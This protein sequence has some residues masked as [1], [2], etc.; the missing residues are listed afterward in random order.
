[1]SRFS[2]REQMATTASAADCLEAVRDTLADLGAGPRMEGAVIVGNLGS[3]A[4]TRLFGSF[5]GSPSWLPVKISAE[6]ID[7]ETERLVIVDVA[8][9]FGFGTL[10]GAEGGF[11]ARCQQVLLQ[12]T[13]GVRSRLPAV[14]ASSPGG[15]PA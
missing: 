1:M 11:R 6:V 9:D 15:T 12:V 14:A 4:K 5:L 3:Q 7:R 2:Y 13:D 10:K 8:E